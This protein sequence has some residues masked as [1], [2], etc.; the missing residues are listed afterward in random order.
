MVLAGAFDRVVLER[1]DGVVYRASIVDFKSDR[2][3]PEEIAARVEYHRPQ[4]EAYREAL[5][6]MTRLPMERIK[7]QIA[8]LQIGHVEE[9]YD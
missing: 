2:V 5:Q 7:V 6:V 9:I 1:R 4:M 8:F 3:E